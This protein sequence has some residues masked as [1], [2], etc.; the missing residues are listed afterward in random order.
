MENRLRSLLKLMEVNCSIEKCSDDSFQSL[1]EAQLK[2]IRANYGSKGNSTC[3]SNGS[4]SNNFNCT[5]NT[6]CS[7]N[8]VCIYQQ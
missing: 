7:G 6:S 4:C 1:D 3:S 8:V 5:G 2:N